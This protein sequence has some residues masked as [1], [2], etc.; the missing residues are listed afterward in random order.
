MDILETD[1]YHREKAEHD[2]LEEMNWQ[3]KQSCTDCGEFFYPD[4]LF[5][6]DGDDGFYCAECYGFRE[7]KAE[8]A[9]DLLKEEK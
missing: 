6:I 5:F 9:Y 7:A 1:R 4:E 2:F 3:E 8:Q